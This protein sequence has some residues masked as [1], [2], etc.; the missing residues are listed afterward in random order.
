[1]ASSKYSSWRKYAEYRE[2]ILAYMC[3][4]KQALKRKIFNDKRI[5][6]GKK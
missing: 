3:N 2:R 4:N 5:K 6:K 1:M